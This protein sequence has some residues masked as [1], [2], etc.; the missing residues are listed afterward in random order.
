M[1]KNYLT[2]EIELTM[3]ST[4]DVIS[5]SLSVELPWLETEI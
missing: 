1:E 3:I 4:E 5:T 2:P